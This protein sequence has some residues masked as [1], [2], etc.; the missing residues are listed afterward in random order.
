MAKMRRI[1]RSVIAA[2]EK[3]IYENNNRLRPSLSDIVREKVFKIK[4]VT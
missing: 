1:I 2:L 3:I 4:C